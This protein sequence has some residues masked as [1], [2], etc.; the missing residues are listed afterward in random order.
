MKKITLVWLFA[1]VSSLS[2]G[3][4]VELVNED[5][6]DE[7]L[8]LG[9]EFL[10]D[11]NDPCDWFF[12]QLVEIGDIFPTT[13]IIF[14]DGLCG[15]DAPSTVAMIETRQYDLSTA[16]SAS[17]TV[18]IG[19]QRASPE[20]QS[21]GVFVWNQ[22]T[23]TPVALLEEFTEDLDPDIQTITYDITSFA[24]ATTSFRFIYNDNP[25]Y[26]AF[27]GQGNR[28]WGGN[29]GIDNFII[30]A[31][32]VDLDVLLSAEPNPE[33]LSLD[34]NT[35]EGFQMFPNPTSNELTISASRNI[36]GVTVFNMLGQNVLE[37]NLSTTNGSINV[38]SLETGAYLLQVRAD[39]QTGTYKFVKQ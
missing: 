12:G 21:F 30:A 36:E 22:L 19:Y 1:F 23:D 15:P 2:F 34:D 10:F 37:Q 35:I 18:D 17:L 39:G 14:D 25:L 26:P 27:N 5:F 9:W 8:P 31:E 7:V 16:T 38:S 24:S 6:Q 33:P 20:I 29:C 4:E 32:G 3:Q 13:A 28:N 11:R